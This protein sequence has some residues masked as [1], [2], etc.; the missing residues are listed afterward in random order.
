MGN[1][2]LTLTN[3]IVK[4]KRL[5][6]KAILE[7]EEESAEAFGIVLEILH[8]VIPEDD[9]LVEMLGKAL[10]KYKRIAME[11]KEEYLVRVGPELTIVEWN[12]DMKYSGTNIRSAL[13]EFAYDENQ[14]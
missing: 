13:Q 5:Q 8:T 6:D 1:S 12:W 10:K 14:S 4:I 7:I 9:S 11:Q 2:S 3:A